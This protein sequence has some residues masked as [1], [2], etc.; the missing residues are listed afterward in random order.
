MTASVT[1]DLWPHPL[2]GEGRAARALD[3]RAGSTVSDLLQRLFDAPPLRLPP[4]VSLAVDGEP[5][6][7]EDWPRTPLRGGEIVTIRR[8]LA[9]GGGGDSDGR[10]VFLA[11]AVI[12]AAH[13]AAPH[14]AAWATGAAVPTAASTSR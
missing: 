5:V 3:C 8:S 13:V 1:V 9:N 11:I 14:V 2:T 6:A 7:A 12:A 4:Q 10:Q